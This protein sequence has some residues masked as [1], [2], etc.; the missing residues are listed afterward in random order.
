MNFEILIELYF[1]ILTNFFFELAS[2]S[3][4]RSVTMSDITIAV[5]GSVSC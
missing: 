2:T 4:T 3:A 1:Y 5:Y